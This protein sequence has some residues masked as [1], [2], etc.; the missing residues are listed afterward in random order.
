[1]SPVIPRYTRQQ[2][3][4]GQSGEVMQNPANAGVVSGAMAGAFKVLG[5]EAEQFGDILVKRRIELKQQADDNAYFELTRNFQKELNKFDGGQRTKIGEDTF[6]NQTEIDDFLKSAKEKYTN[7]ITDP[8]LTSKIGQYV[9]T[10]GGSVAHSHAIYQANER[11]KGNILSLDMKRDIAKETASIGTIPLASIIGQHEK[12]IQL[13]HLDGSLD[14]PTAEQTTIENTH[15]IAKA[16]AD[17]R[18]AS[19]PEAFLEL[20][21]A[22]Y[23]NRYLPKQVVNELTDKAEKLKQAQERDARANAHEIERLRGNA[24]KEGREQTGINFSKLRAEGKLTEKAI[25]SSNLEGT[26]ENSINSWLKTLEDDRKKKEKGEEVVIKTNT[27]IEAQWYEEIDAAED[28]S[29]L[30]NSEI[31]KDV[32]AGKMSVDEANKLI[33]YRDK[34][35]KGDD[36]LKSE[37]VKNARTQL[38]DAKT[39]KLFDSEDPAVN[40]AH[41]GKY[42]GL[43]TRYIENNPKASPEEIQGFI[44]TIM[45]PVKQNL[46]NSILDSLRPGTPG[47]DEMI[48]AKE[49]AIEALAGPA[50]RK[51]VLPK[52]GDTKILSS[53]NTAIFKG[54]KRVLKK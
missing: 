7:D 11:K 18:I 44:D 12:E 20:A 38:N 48:K 17:G 36:P 37:A 3:I 27:I 21:K 2:S 24:I 53:G 51:E 33:T 16:H 29:I 25:L 54:G 1:M 13:K 34:L 52:E 5:N 15:E 14:Q 30:T 50:K 6:N 19:S 45:E 32:F 31:R 43:F 40:A 35:I 49:S 46:I 28:P 22:G 8:V 42:H 39:K 9:D 23:Y 26:G 47:I 10:Q 4:P 41:W